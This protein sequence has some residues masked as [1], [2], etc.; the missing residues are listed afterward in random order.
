[1]ML[2]GRFVITGKWQEGFLK[3]SRQYQKG[4]ED[5]GKVSDFIEVVSV[6]E[7]CQGLIS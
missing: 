2:R 1:M 4:S 6:K 3:C 7:L 5:T